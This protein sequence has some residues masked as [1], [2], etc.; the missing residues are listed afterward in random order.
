MKIT[1]NHPNRGK[2][3]MEVKTLGKDM[4]EKR[5]AFNTATKKNKNNEQELMKSYLQS[6]FKLGKK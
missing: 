1:T 5:N 6:Q 2:E 4:K 3:S